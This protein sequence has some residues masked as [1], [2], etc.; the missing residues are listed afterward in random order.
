MKTSLSSPAYNVLMFSIFWALQII[1]AKFVFNAGAD[2][3]P[4]Q[5]LSTFIA[6]LILLV[7]IYPKVKSQLFHL[8]KDQ[9][10]LFWKLFAANGIQAGFGTCFALVGIALTNAIN[11]GFLVKLTTV[12]TILFAWILLKE[13][14]SVLKVVIVFMMLLGAYLLTTKAQVLIPTTGDLFI[15]GAC[16]CWSL[17]TVLVRMVLKDRPIEA[18]VVTMQKPLASFPV[19]LSFVGVSLIFS[20]SS[21]V[22]NHVFDCCQL[23]SAELI[24]ILLSGF[25]VAMAWIFLYRTL[26][27]ST[28][29]YLTMM[30]MLTPVIVSLLALVFLGETLI[31]IQVVGAAM[32]ILS[33]ILVYFSDIAYA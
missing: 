12:S 24:Y 9:N 8:Y 16:V 26:K 2:V 14:L 4:F 30:S 3:L 32:I 18:D 17:G 33:G 10:S 31:W 22:F 25:C 21:S 27:I 20:S 6:F 11:A 13:R 29:S 5:L 7:F 1:F 15:L 19:I 23:P 28:A